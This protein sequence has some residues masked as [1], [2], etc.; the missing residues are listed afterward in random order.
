[1]AEILVD[2]DEQEGAVQFTHQTVKEF[3][4]DNDP[5][6]ASA[7]FRFHLKEVNLYAGEICVTYLNFNHFSRKLTEQPKALSL[8]GPKG[9]L[10]ATLLHLETRT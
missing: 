1:M 4:L 9:I 7:G 6:R 10:R 8:P 5:E 2:L 3:F